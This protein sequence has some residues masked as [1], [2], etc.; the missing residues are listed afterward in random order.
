MQEYRRRNS[1]DKKKEAAR[2]RHIEIPALKKSNAET[3]K[4]EF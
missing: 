2:K 4:K 3:L 1:S